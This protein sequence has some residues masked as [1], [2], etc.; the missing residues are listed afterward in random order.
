M[1]KTGRSFKNAVLRHFPKSNPSVIS[2]R[3]RT[4][5]A[6]APASVSETE[7]TIIFTI[8]RMNPPTPGHM[9]LVKTL[10]EAGGKSKVYILLQAGEKAGKETQNPLTCG[11]KK[12]YLLEMIRSL[13]PA[14]DNVEVICADDKLHKDCTQDSDPLRQIC[15]IYKR[16]KFTPT[17]KTTFYLWVGT[18][19]VDS[20]KKFLG[21]VKYLPPNSE[22]VTKELKREAGGIS[23][24]KMRELAKAGKDEDFIKLEMEAGLSKESARELYEILYE[25]MDS[26]PP[27]YKKPSTAKSASAAKAKTG[28][29][30]G[31]KRGYKQKRKTKRKKINRNKR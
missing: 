14:G 13:G 15:D 11:E 3:R 7:Q 20:F 6:S 22:L 1:S 24:T 4:A 25:R 30:K 8:A 12:K 28:T 5:S 9:Q 2:H 19:R 10:I 26:L 16:E 29:K 21:N 23:G 27:L 18:D 17:K 31:G